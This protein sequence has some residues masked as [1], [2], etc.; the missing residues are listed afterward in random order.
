MT[1]N[2]Y[3]LNNISQNRSNS[4]TSWLFDSRVSGLYTGDCPVDSLALYTY[5]LM[6]HRCDMGEGSHTTDRWVTDPILVRGVTIS[7]VR[8]PYFI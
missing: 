8:K 2:Q 3:C 6:V 7:F 1:I 5:M 4:L